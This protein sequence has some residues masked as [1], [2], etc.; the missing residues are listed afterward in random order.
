MSPEDQEKVRTKLGIATSNKTEPCCD[1]AT[2]MGMMNGK[3]IDPSAMCKEMMGKCQ[4][5][6]CASPEEVDKN[7]T[8]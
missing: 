4:Q 7:E 8:C 5:T 2:M 3:A 6:G 1:M